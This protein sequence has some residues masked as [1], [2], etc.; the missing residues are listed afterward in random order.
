MGTLP[1][2]I[3]M[4]LAS[5]PGA[6]GNEADGDTQSVTGG[7]RVESRPKPANTPPAT[8]SNWIPTLKG[9][10]SLTPGRKLPRKGPLLLAG[11]LEGT[12]G[13][14]FDAIREERPRDVAD[15]AV[16]VGHPVL[17]DAAA[18]RRVREGLRVTDI[19]GQDRAGV[20]QA[21][22]R[23]RAGKESGGARLLQG[24]VDSEDRGVAG[25]RDAQDRALDID[26]RDRN[27]DLAAIRLADIGA[28]AVRD[29]DALTQ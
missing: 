7:G 3:W 17:E 21:R 25:A 27:A 12:G 10:H 20:A 22:G 15:R 5:R 11:L 19:A 14:R 24:H 18:E 29:L 16:A 13:S 4:P 23:I 2:K 26:H 28:R 1:G 8:R 6:I 9:L